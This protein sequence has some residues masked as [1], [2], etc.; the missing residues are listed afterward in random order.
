MRKLTFAVAGVVALVATSIAVAH[1][2]DGAKTAAAVSGTFSATPSGTVTTR[3]CTTTDNKTITIADAKYTGTADSS[4]ADLKGPITLR[5]R[6]V[7]NSTDNV[8]WVN[9]AYRIDVATGGD[10]VGAFSTVFDH[11][12]IAGWTA[13]RAHTP[14]ARLRGNISAAFAASTGF[15]G[16]KIGGGTASGAAVE[17]GPASCKPTAPPVEKSAAKGTVSAISAD[18][19]TVA[20]L[21]CAIPSAMSAAV[22]AKV[23]QCDHAEIHCTLQNGQN[24]L[25]RVEK[26]R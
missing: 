26:G 14:Y 17:I 16:G 7:I 1:G 6:S 5:A 22:N 25:T 15:S 19:I 13:G 10:T 8:G 20:G 4:N 23:K 9:G 12:T 24:T 3:T 2:I 21:T 11:G 18:S